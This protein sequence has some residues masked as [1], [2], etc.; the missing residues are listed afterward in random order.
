MLLRVRE[1][2]FPRSI[3]DGGLVECVHV[4]LSRSQRSNHASLAVA[5]QRVLQQ[6]RQL[7]ISVPTSHAY[8]SERSHAQTEN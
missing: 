5:P 7:A 4:H 3:H 8:V 6:E 1:P 2:A